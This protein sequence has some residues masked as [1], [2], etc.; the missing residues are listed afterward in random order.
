MADKTA[1]RRHEPA[2][3]PARH[4]IAVFVARE[5][6][7]RTVRDDDQLTAS[8]HDGNPSPPGLPER[9]LARAA[10]DNELDVACLVAGEPVEE[11]KPVAKKPR[12]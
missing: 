10:A 11:R 6:D 7:R 1:E 2:P 4:T 8:G 5:R 12:R 3:A 9:P